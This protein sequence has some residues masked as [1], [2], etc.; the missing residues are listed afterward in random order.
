MALRDRAETF[1]N[2]AVAKWVQWGLTLVIT[3][4]LVPCVVL[5]LE[6][7]VNQQ[8]IMAN[9]FTAEDG[10]KVWQELATKAN[11][12]NVPPPQ[13]VEALARLEEKLDQLNTRLSRIE[14]R[15]GE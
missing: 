5:V 1:I 10:Q 2:G 13:V 9:R 6:M 7:Y 14:G 3:V 4:V 15:L 12:D 8:I 11:K